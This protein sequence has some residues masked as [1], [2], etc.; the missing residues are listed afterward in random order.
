MLNELFQIHEYYDEFKKIDLSNLGIDY[1]PNLSSF[2][3]IEVLDL[4][5]NNISKNLK[6][7]VNIT[8]LKILNLSS[9]NI[10]KIPE[11]LTALEN[12]EKL[13]L[14]G[15]P[16]SRIKGINYK[17]SPKEIMEFILFHQD[18]EMIPL[19]EAK[20]LILGDENS[21]KSSLVERLVYDRFN[22]E[23]NSTNGIDINDELE[24]DN[25]NVKIKIWDFAGQEITYQIHNLFM[26]QESLYLLVIDG[27]KEDDMLEHFSWLETIS[28]NA[29]YPPIIIVVTK[30][31]T[32]RTYRLDEELYIK[33]FSNI[34]GICYVSSKEN[35]KIKE[36]KELI[37]KEINKISDINFPKE[38]EKV[39]KEIEMKG[40][41]YI[42]EPSEFKKNC[43]EC[44]F[45]SK[46]ERA[47]IRKV[48]TDIGTIIGLDRDD[49][50][51]VNPNIIIDNMYKIIRSREVDDRGEMP[52]KDDDDGDYT[53][54]I[55]FLIK[56]KIAFKID[57]L[58]VMIPSRLPVN[59]PDNFSLKSY[60]GIKENDKNFE[61]GLNYRYR[62]IH[63]FKRG[64]LFDFIIQ[65]Q[66]SIKKY[67]PIYW[68]NG[69]CWEQNGV[70]VAIL[71]NRINKFLDIHIPTSDEKSRALLTTIRYE[72]EKINQE[73][74]SVFAV[75]E[76]AIFKDDEIK[77]YISYGFLVSKKKNGDTE[78]E[79]EIHQKPYKYKLSDLLERYEFVEEKIEDDNS[80]PL[81]ITEG[82]TDWKHLKK[83]L[84]RFKN[85]GL[86]T[87]LDIEFKEYED[88]IDM[89]EDNL[90]QMLNANIKDEPERKKIFIFDR[91]T[92]H[93]DVKKYQ[94]VEFTKHT[95]KVY[96]VCIPKIDDLDDGICIEFFYD[97]KDLKKED[98]NARRLFLGDE[99]LVN[100]NGNSSCGK[101]QTKL[102]N[103]A[104]KSLEIID[105]GVY[106]REDYE[107]KDSIALSKNEFA[108]NI[109][110][111]VDG[112]N[113][114]DI[115]NFKL[116]FDIIEKIVN[117]KSLKLNK[118][119]IELITNY[120]K[121]TAKIIQA[122]QN[123]SID[124]F[125]EIKVELAQ[126]V[127]KIMQQSAK[128]WGNVK[129]QKALERKKYIEDIL[130]GDK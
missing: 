63:G 97:K 43:K 85:N 3:D 58:T 20:I 75:E 67:N 96:S 95:D 30:N 32:N 112:F 33:K 79:V 13:N 128:T 70:K 126:E 71:L 6:R 76:I 47:N 29:H 27:Q 88:E 19:N 110:N 90:N 41:D 59:R 37:G 55:Q 68:A 48:L 91:D 12:L 101:F 21:G 22:P 93:K 122:M 102:Q 50:H 44:G 116:I 57:D 111:D 39:K 81:I 5:C 113:D 89:G 106:L 16:V 107:M 92:N 86:Y 23:Y 34:V 127:K 74:T 77:K 11:N 8:T 26:S 129:Q 2:H 94:K 119:V 104:G 78:V 46:E 66:D 18:K 9:N 1:I 49:R 17:K 4:S 25:S 108:E 7:L 14:K 115:E 15:N 118:Q 82:K 84:E 120:N 53:W 87:D 38:Y 64:I 45:E 36:L 54:I 103:K 100:T 73:D 125:E 130:N 42:L 28:A 124:N 52:I 56:N 51:I 31:E 83:A 24:L 121:D 61:Q 114:F 69:V 109:L 99:F 80:K 40:N 65:M 60:Q 123:G 62:Y 10:E 72:F 117:E 35:I 98:K 105:S